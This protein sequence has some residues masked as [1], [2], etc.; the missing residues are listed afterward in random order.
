MTMNNKKEPNMKEPPKQMSNTQQQEQQQQQKFAVQWQA[1]K[2]ATATP[3]FSVVPK[4]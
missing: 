3:L 2:Q 1:S 4:L